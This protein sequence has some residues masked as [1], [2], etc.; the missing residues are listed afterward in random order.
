MK[1]IVSIIMPIFNVSGTIHFTLRSILNQTF[2]NFELLIIDDDSTDTSKKISKNYKI[3]DSRIKILSSNSKGFGFAKNLGLQ[4]SNGKYILFFKCGNLMSENL[5]EYLVR[6]AE[7]KKASIIS[8]DYFNLPEY[9]FINLEIT[10]PSQEKE[11]ITYFS[12]EDYLYN[13]S[14]NNSHIV[15]QTTILFNKLIDKKILKNFT[16]PTDK[17]YSDCFSIFE[18]INKSPQIAYSNQKLIANT[19]IDEYYNNICF[20][21][22]ELEKIEFMQNLLVYFKS[23]KNINAIKNTSTNLL[24]LLYKI[25]KKL[26]YYYLDIFDKEEQRKNIDQKFSSLNKFFN[27]HYPDTNL[28][29]IEKYKQLLQEEKFREKHFYLYPQA[30]LHFEKFEIDTSKKKSL[31]NK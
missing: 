19:L 18:L 21:Y 12:P 27:S 6:L 25:R 24:E 16:F 22:L 10:P 31:P 29:Y 9:D 14:S 2:T 8:C 3:E 15:E 30:P 13:L 1:P 11:L 17:Y 20:S 23:Q 26:S 5:L 4:S 28:E 7:K